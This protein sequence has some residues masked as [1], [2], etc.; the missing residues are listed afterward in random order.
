V[1]ISGT[2]TDA[3]GPHPLG[4]DR[5]CLL[6]FGAPCAA[7]GDRAQLRAGRGADAPLHRGIGQGRRRYLHQLLSERRLAQSDERH[8]L[9][10][11]ARDDRSPDGDFAKAGF[12]NIAGG[13]CGT[14]PSTSPR[15]RGALAAYRPRVAHE[16]AGSVLCAARAGG[17]QER[18]SCDGARSSQAC[19]TA[20]RACGPARSVPRR[21]AGDAAR[22]VPAPARP[23]SRACAAAAPHD[24]TRTAWSSA[25]GADP[26]ARWPR[27]LPKPIALVSTRRARLELAAPGRSVLG[28]HLSAT[29]CPTGLLTR[30]PACPAPARPPA[31]DSSRGEPG[32]NG[33]A[34]GDR[35]HRG[36]GRRCRAACP[37]L[38]AS[39]RPG[40]C[41]RGAQRRPVRAAPRLSRSLGSCRA[42]M[43]RHGADSTARWYAR[44]ASVRHWTSCNRAVQP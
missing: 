37:A 1:I 19:C 9:R 42:R 36:A 44:N 40:E 39:T 31:R 32:P 30:A 11:D 15:S 21:H 25:S 18:P 8:R 17:H 22:R 3:S 43:R 5:G 26:P 38:A 35:R 33:P 28:R 27:P 13:C 6:A 41:G 23:G 2:V 24:A 12:L 29:G 14:T 20:G 34:S 4:S 7:A 10:R 16:P